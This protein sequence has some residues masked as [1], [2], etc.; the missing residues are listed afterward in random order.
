MIQLP[1]GHIFEVK[2]LIHPP[3]RALAY[4]RYVPDPRGDRAGGGLR[5][6][7]LS[8]WEERMALVEAD[9]GRYVVFDPVLGDVF[10]EIPLADASHV[11]DPVGKLA[12]LEEEGGDGLAGLVLEMVDEVAD[13][14][15]VSR[16]ELGV[17]GS[18]LVGLEGPSSDIDIVVY[19]REAC[20]EVYRALRSM[21]EEGETRPL[22]P[23][24]LMAIYEARSADTPYDLRTFLAREP[25]KLLQGLFRGRAYSIRLIPSRAREPYGLLRFRALGTSTIRAT[26]EDA[27]ESIFTPCRYRISEVEVLSGP[28]GPKPTALSSFRLRFCEHARVGE[29]VEARGKLEAVYGPGGLLEVRL[30]VGGRKGDYIWPLGP[31]P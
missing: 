12:E 23:E 14:A 24:E 1:A 27:S 8:G 28:P 26:V 3:G 30:L 21:R 16:G 7:K 4:P 25:G 11:F 10:C 17:S 20:L 2:G 9:F 29:L 5:F 13:R 31:P 6:R 19:G 15:S 22:G 18:L